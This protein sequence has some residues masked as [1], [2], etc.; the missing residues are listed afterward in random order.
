RLAR[1][2]STDLPILQPRPVT[3]HS[4]HI[5]E[6]AYPR[7]VIDIRCGKGTYIRSLARDLGRA[8]HTGGMLAALRRTQVGEF[9]IE[10]SLSFA[11]LPPKLTPADLL[12]IP[13]G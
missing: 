13:T 5:V 1:R 10:Q 4:I 2:E 3:I 7:L 12:P 8:L 11:A 9:T 6:Y